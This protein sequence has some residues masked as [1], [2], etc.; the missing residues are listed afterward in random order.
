METPSDFTL[1]YYDK[2]GVYFGLKPV[3][4]LLHNKTSDYLYNL[5]KQY[6]KFNS[7]K[8]SL[9]LLDQGAPIE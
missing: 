3:Y 9:D 8:A 4:L 2:V 6:S 5:V 1:V 7:F